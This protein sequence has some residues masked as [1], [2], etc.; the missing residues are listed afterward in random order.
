MLVRAR[1][2]ERWMN[3]QRKREREM[4]K[5]RKREWIFT[6]HVFTYMKAKG[7][8]ILCNKC[9]AS[10]LL[11]PLEDKKKD[12]LGSRGRGRKRKGGRRDAFFLFTASL[13]AV[14]L[15]LWNTVMPAP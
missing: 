12:S 14:C 6:V 4:K 8:F 3:R 5:E 10:A 1:E 13:K 2:K 9:I 11:W 7:F 15:L